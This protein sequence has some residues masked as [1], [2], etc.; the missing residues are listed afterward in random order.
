[1][2]IRRLELMTAD[3]P[4]A[5]QFY[6]GTLGLE[7]VSQ[8]AD[9]MA[10]RAGSSELVF[11]KAPQGWQGAYH[12]A[13]NIPEDRFEEHYEW[14]RRTTGLLAN[15]QGQMA[16]P[17]PD[18]NSDGLYFRDPAGNILEFIAR[19]G[20]KETSGQGAGAPCILSVSEIGV[21]TEDVRALV[22]ELSKIGLE[23]Y[24]GQSEEFTAVGDAYGLLIV[25]KR[26]RIWMPDSGVP[27]EL[28]PVSVLMGVNG[29]HFQIRGVPY[30]IR[31][32]RTTT[33][34]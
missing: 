3:V 8:A 31:G 13:F 27:A 34:Y 26:G 21:A 24:S 32:V 14:A 4:A 7:G 29:G 33:P 22:D 20:L 5:L 18:W 23:P 16:F 11:R 2:E 12:F 1:M 17:S 10:V 15:R 28:L 25:V 30:T 19:H 6:T 9:F